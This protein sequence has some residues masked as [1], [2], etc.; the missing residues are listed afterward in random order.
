[1]SLKQK[2]RDYPALALFFPA[3]PFLRFAGP[4]RQYLRSVRRFLDRTSVARCASFG[5]SLA[6]ALTCA[7]G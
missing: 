5:Q 6:S 1:M 4:R 3:F 2:I 7:G